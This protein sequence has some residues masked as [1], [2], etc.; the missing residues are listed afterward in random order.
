MKKITDCFEQRYGNLLGT[1]ANVNINS[2]KGDRVLFDVAC[3]L[4][5]NVW[6]NSVETKEESCDRQLRSLRNM[7]LRYGGMGILAS[8]T[9]DEIVESF[10][11]IVRY[12]LKYFNLTGIGVY[13]FWAKIF[14]L[15]D[16]NPQWNP[17][18]LII[19]MCMCASISNA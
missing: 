12:G 19:E 11:S 15:I 10:L 3:H 2:D 8:I 7:I 9:E 13:D 17:A 18:L 6:Q 16:D 5:C 1:D 14:G 4:N